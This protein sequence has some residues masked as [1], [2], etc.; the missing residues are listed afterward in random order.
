MLCIAAHA[1]GPLS[2]VYLCGAF[3]PFL[4]SQVVKERLLRT[5]ARTAEPETIYSS[6]IGKKITS[7]AFG[8]KIRSY[9]AKPMC[10]AFGFAVTLPR[11]PIDKANSHSR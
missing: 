4:K 3:A 7:N 1:Q 2:E 5:S 9:R 6:G 10:A 8:N 11:D